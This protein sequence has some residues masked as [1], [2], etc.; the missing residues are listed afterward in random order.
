MF[1]LG[2]AVTDGL[3]ADCRG[4]RI[5]ILI[6][7]YNAITTLGKV[8]KR[9][10]P[11]VWNNVEEVVVFDDASHD[12][13]YELAVGYQVLS[14]MKKLNVIKNR[15]N[16][17]YGGNQKAGYRYFMEKGFDVVVL[18]H[19]DGQYAPEVL[20]HFY[21]PLVAGDADAVFGS[22]T[23][24]HYGG[25]RKGGMPL[26]KYVGNRILTFFE[27]HALNM[28]L[29]EFHSGYRAYGLHALRQIDFSRMTDDFHFDT[30]NIIKLQH[31][32]FRRLHP[33]RTP[34]WV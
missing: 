25:P 14:D 23:M 32:G 7:A 3:L 11:Q 26:Y 2:L 5:G 15:Q 19:R 16:L 21:H 29:T 8:L 1:A 24:P 28:N 20:S 33:I 9:I 4:K 17:G 6:V 13:T 34:G 22:R 30:Q 31:Q 18:P 27:N 12:S 10:T